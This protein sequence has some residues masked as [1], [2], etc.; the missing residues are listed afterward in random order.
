MSLPV[1]ARPHSLHFAL[2]HIVHMR[3][4]FPSFSLYCH[5]LIVHYVSLFCLRRCALCM[6]NHSACNKIK[7]NFAFHLLFVIW[8][9]FFCFSGFFQINFAFSTAFCCKR[10]TCTLQ[11]TIEMVR[12]KNLRHWPHCDSSCGVWQMTIERNEFPRHCFPNTTHETDSHSK[13]PSPKINNAT[14][15]SAKIR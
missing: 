1:S 2:S 10:M 8:L 5:R 4:L 13:K 7:C 3:A 12:I 14:D 6:W 15:L 11:A 9:V